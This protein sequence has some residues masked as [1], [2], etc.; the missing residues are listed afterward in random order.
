MGHDKAPAPC[1]TQ[2]MMLTMSAGIL[3]S[4]V[5]LFASDEHLLRLY[6]VV[7][8]GLALIA[9][10]FVATQRFLAIGCYD[11]PMPPPPLQQQQQPPLGWWS[12]L[13]L[14][15][16][17]VP[18]FNHMFGDAGP[19]PTT[20][21]VENVQCDW[22]AYTLAV[23]LVTAHLVVAGGLAN[24]IS[25]TSS[26]LERYTLLFLV[27]LFVVPC[28]LK[29]VG[30][31]QLDVEDANRMACLV[32]RTGLQIWSGACLERM[33]YNSVCKQRTE[34]TVTICNSE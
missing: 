10:N 9:S 21:E 11:D 7:L 25:V 34:L 32:A 18:F 29:F 2:L 20:A 30:A 13:V 23:V 16:R 17:W 27:N 24:L 4:L 19:P 22:D 1:H 8:P 26:R 33:L 6:K 28:T 12:S 3:L 31:S 5:L 15:F 14:Y